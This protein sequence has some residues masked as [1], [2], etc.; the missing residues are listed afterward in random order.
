MSK[1]KE[2][3]IAL[4]DDPDL[5]IPEGESRESAAW[6]ETSQRMR[7]H[8][9]NSKALALAAE[10][11]VEKLLNFTSNPE[12]LPP[13]SLATLLKDIDIQ[14]QKAESPEEK[15]YNRMRM[16]ALREFHPDAHVN[17]GEKEKA[18]HNDAAK[19]LNSLHDRHTKVGSIPL[20]VQVAEIRDIKTQHAQK[21]SSFQNLLKQFPTDKLSQNDLD[22]F[23]TV[24]A[25]NFQLPVNAIDPFIKRGRIRRDQFKIDVD[26]M[27]NFLKTAKRLKK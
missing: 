17:A 15:N 21:F 10:S 11:P 9:T 23:K 12:F 16:K 24:M 18:F 13:P 25:R 27:I 7:Q 20:E 3:Y 26:K 4:R 1:V 6:N 19:K 2:L 14:L 5:D 22:S 8:K